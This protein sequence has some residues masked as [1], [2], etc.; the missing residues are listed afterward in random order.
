M[1]DGITKILSKHNVKAVSN[2]R[3]SVTRPHLIS[4]ADCNT[5]TEMLQREEISRSDR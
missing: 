1:T 5:R 3:N 4:Y 2:A